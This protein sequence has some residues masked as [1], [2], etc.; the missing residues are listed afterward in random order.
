MR[1]DTKDT[2][3]ADVGVDNKDDGDENDQQVSTT[4]KQNPNVVIKKLTFDDILLIA[5]QVS[6]FLSEVTDFYQDIE[7][8]EKDHNV[9]V[10]NKIEE[11]NQQRRAILEQCKAA[12]VAQNGQ[13]VAQNGNPGP[14][15][16]FQKKG[17]K[18]ESSTT[19]TQPLLDY[20]ID[21]LIQVQLDQIDQGIAE[22]EAK[23]GT[24]IAPSLA[25]I[26][27]YLYQYSLIDFLSSYLKLNAAPDVLVQLK[28]E[29]VVSDRETNIAIDRFLP[30]PDHSSVIT[31]IQSQCPDLL[32]PKPI[33]Q[34]PPPLAPDITPTPHLIMTRSC[35]VTSSTIKSTHKSALTNT[36][37]VPTTPHLIPTF[38]NIDGQPV[39]TF[40]S[41]NKQ[42]T[43]ATPAEEN[44]TTKRIFY[45]PTT[46]D[47]VLVLF[48]LGRV[49]H[50]HKN[51]YRVYPVELAAP[52]LPAATFNPY[53]IYTATKDITEKELAITPAILPPQSPIQQ[54]LPDETTPPTHLPGANPMSNTSIYPFSLQFVD[55]KTNRVALTPLIPIPH[56]LLPPIPSEIKKDTAKVDGKKDTRK[57]VG[58]GDKKTQ[59]EPNSDATASLTPLRIDQNLFLVPFSF[60]SHVYTGLIPS[61]RQFA[62]EKAQINGGYDYDLT[63]GEQK[64]T[65]IDKNDHLIDLATL[66]EFFQN[67]PALLKIRSEIEAE[68]VA[69]Q[70]K[71]DKAVADA[72]KAN[73]KA[74]KNNNGPKSK[75]P[76]FKSKSTLQDEPTP[77]PTPVPVTLKDLPELPVP[78]T[79]TR[80]LEL[81]FD[82]KITDLVVQVQFIDTNVVSQ[83]E[84]AAINQ[85]RTE[86][87]HLEGDERRL[88]LAKVPKTVRVS[89]AVVTSLSKTAHFGTVY[90]SV[91]S[92]RP[93]T[94]P[95]LNGVY[96]ADVAAQQLKIRTSLR[97]AEPPLSP[98]QITDETLKV[99]LPE[100]ATNL[101]GHLYMVQLV[102]PEKQVLFSQLEQSNNGNAPIIGQGGKDHHIS[103]FNHSI[104]QVGATKDQLL[105]KP[106]HLFDKNKFDRVSLENDLNFDWNNI[107]FEFFRVTNVAPDGTS[108]TSL[109]AS[110][111]VD[112]LALPATEKEE[113]VSKYSKSTNPLASLHQK[114]TPA[115]L[116]PSTSAAPFSM[117]IATNSIVSFNF[118]C[119]NLR[120]E[121]F[122]SEFSRLIPPTLVEELTKL[123]VENP[124]TALSIFEQRH[125]FKRPQPQIQQQQVLTQFGS[126]KGKNAIVFTQNAKTVLK[127]LKNF[128]LKT[129]SLG[130]KSGENGQDNAE[131]GDDSATAT[132]PKGRHITP[133]KLAFQ[134]LQNTAQKKRQEAK[135]AKDAAAKD[136]KNIKAKD[137]DNKT[138]VVTKG[139]KKIVVAKTEKGETT[140]P[141]PIITTTTTTTT[142]TTASPLPTIPAQLDT[143]AVT[144]TATKT[145]GKKGVK[146][147]KTKA[148]TKGKEVV[149]VNA[150][151]VDTTTTPIT[152]PTPVATPTEKKKLTVVKKEPTK[153]KQQQAPIQADVA[154][155][156]AP[157]AAAAAA[158]VIVTPTATTPTTKKT[159]LRTPRVTIARTNHK[160]TTPAPASTTTTTPAPATTTKTTTPNPPQQSFT[161]PDLASALASDPLFAPLIPDQTPK[162]DVTAAKDVK[163]GAVGGSKKK[164]GGQNKTLSTPATT[165][166]ST[167]TLTTATAPA[168]ATS[169]SSSTTTKKST[170]PQPKARVTGD[171]A[172][173]AG[174]IA[175]TTPT[176]ADDKKIEKAEKVTPAPTTTPSP[177]ASTDI[178]PTEKTDGE[179]T[180]TAKKPYKPYN[181]TFGKPK[182]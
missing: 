50:N 172:G 131:G 79:Q 180:P 21:D 126:S 176:T 177:T 144:T 124:S 67:Y 61:L 150:K 136:A 70:A 182:K 140:T 107:T 114:K 96:L 104:G 33:S 160:T 24:F 7:T 31:T 15:G 162:A 74:K 47:K 37:L 108:G 34:L 87:D 57:K 90:A 55:P 53:Y 17:K 35:V 168:E 93:A 83:H 181:K 173:N 63:L 133:T 84:L 39:S 112:Y 16:K 169:P 19:P 49:F 178:K 115:Q 41:R 30:R 73:N 116:T 51:P 59:N 36:T 75:D 38:N 157:A 91:L 42:P 4:Q 149:D 161:Q 18:P 154:P 179:Q 113:K 174:K 28:G 153:A 13:N 163:T 127:G 12:V 9:V 132:G 129:A 52:A 125:P 123:H 27:E 5:R 135:D 10:E 164:F 32:T 175:A 8:L 111:P 60:I 166:S 139:G 155:T 117:F 158:A 85:A 101:L 110:T 64:S 71:A 105:A 76:K 45:Q 78:L 46:G 95:V 81:L 167:T 170:R 56:H 143:A 122:A 22:L 98:Q 3:D 89:K 100:G 134:Q 145:A 23:K 97:F 54:I 147:I 86:T 25:H 119:D 44:N 138:K 151:E 72:I 142:T 118:H 103:N 99:P 14:K 68:N 20:V 66:F 121:L 94:I 48:D 92:C 130:S 148:T 102:S 29:G 165:D 62:V 40:D 106:T 82:K 1:V 58:K 6:E 80:M 152:T 43:A 156:S 26:D 128:G 65:K 11:L 137:G 69:A 88:A 141:T 146:D 120:R 159:T 2:K 109:A 171:K 77:V